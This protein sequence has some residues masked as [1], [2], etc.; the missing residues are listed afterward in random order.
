MKNKSQKTSSSHSRTPSKSNNEDKQNTKYIAKADNKLQSKDKKTQELESFEYV[1]DSYEYANKS[2]SGAMIEP[3]RCSSSDITE[4]KRLQK[5]LADTNSKAERSESPL[6]FNQLIGR[7]LI[8]KCE[9]EPD[10]NKDKQKN[11]AGLMDSPVMSRKFPV[12]LYELIN[13]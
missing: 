4:I 7:N 13:L 1:A 3:H 8:K 11:D 2:S 5:Y 9:P 10:S 6:S 12:F